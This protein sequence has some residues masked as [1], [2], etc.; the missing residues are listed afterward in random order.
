MKFLIL[1]TLNPYRNLA[2]EEYLFS[3]ESDDI[4]ML[5]QNEP[6]VVIGKNQNPHAEINLD[7]LTQKGIHI[8]R[9]I[10]GGGAVYHDLGNVNYTFISGKRDT[11]GLDFAFFTSPIIEALA[12]VGITAALTGRNDLAIDGLKFSGNAQHESGDRVLHHGTLLFDSDLD[13][14]ASVLNVDEEKILSK[15]V[16]ST[17]SRVTNLS[18]F[19][20]HGWGVQDFISLISDFVK[21]K[22]SPEM[23]DMPKGDKVEELYLKYSS[24]EW[25]F[26]TTGIASG[27]TVRKKHRYPFGGVEVLLDFRGDRISYVKIVGDFFGFADVKEI[28]D[29]LCGAHL[30][31]ITER[32]S[33]LDIGKYIFGMTSEELSSLIISD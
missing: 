32:I 23:I 25:L 22:F 29:A 16:K 28:E 15:G 31:E 7:Y 9:R 12:S 18:P 6:T 8:A 21:A 14:L 30:S 3:E 2:V 17:R 33:R 5:W 1:D 24:D 19:L 27:H 13:V 20:P 10:T 26:P 4:F 11:G